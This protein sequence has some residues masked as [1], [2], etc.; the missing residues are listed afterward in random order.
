MRQ[1]LKQPG[2]RAFLLIWFGQLISLTGSGLTGFAL[3]VWV[4]LSTGSVTQFALI[5]VSTTL[6]A[7]LFSPIAGALVDRW[8]RRI[9]MIVSDAGAGVSTLIIALLLLTEQLEIW[10]IYLLVGISSTFSA[11][12]WP[13]YTAATTLLIPKEHFG[14]ASGLVQLAEAAAQIVAPMLAGALLGL[15]QVQG[16]LLIDFATFLV[17]LATLLI[18]RIPRPAQT[19]EGATGKG[20]L[21]QEA[22]YGWRYIKTRRGLLGLLLLFATTNFYFG[23][24][25]ILFTPL[26]LSFTTPAVLGVLMS[27]VGVGLLAGSL[28]MSAWGG[29]KRRIRGIIGFTMLQGLAMHLAG[30]P[31]QVALIAPSVFVIFFISPIVNGCSQAIWMSKTPPDVQGRVFSV[32]R[33][34][35]WST[36]PLSYLIAGPLADMVFEPMMAEGGLLASS[37]GQFIGVGEGRGVGLLFIVLSTL[38][39]ITALLAFQYAPLRNVEGDLPD[40]IGDGGLAAGSRA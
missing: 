14:R 31:P 29:P 23:I 21:L 38:T 16:I 17:A 3:G 15:I 18:V 33:M 27:I 9:A 25:T 4:Y 30:A 24:A 7:I 37:V 8:D 32:R 1:I 20:S 2:L 11:F 19:A 13:A 10:H 36:M 28:T 12:Q 22:V 6:P 34:I 39:V 5:S 26:V 35:A 40:A